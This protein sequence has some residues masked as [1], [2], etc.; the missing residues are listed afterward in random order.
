MMLGGSFVWHPKFQPL[1]IRII[2]KSHPSV[3]GMPNIW[4]KEDECYFMKELYPGIHVVMAHDLTSIDPGEKEVEK[5]KSLSSN[6]G[7]YY[8]AAWCQ[9]FDGGTIWITTLGHHKK[10]YEDPTFLNH[11]FQGMTFVASRSGKVDFSR[12]YATERNTPIR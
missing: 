3:T 9:N 4:V 7:D 8:P 2:D 6:F 10:D 12:S 5:M 1:N 11:V